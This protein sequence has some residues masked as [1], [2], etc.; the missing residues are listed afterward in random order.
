MR[1]RTCI[2]SIA[3]GIGLSIL[4]TAAAYA[5]PCDGPAF[6]QFDF[7]LGEWQVH[8]PDGKLAGSNRITR[9]YGGCVIHEHYSTKLGFSGESLNIY[10]ASR[11]VW[12]VYQKRIPQTTV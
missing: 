10:D 7:W 6:R 11:K 9:E 4:T 5:G 8:K 1:A 2:H 3:A 12:L